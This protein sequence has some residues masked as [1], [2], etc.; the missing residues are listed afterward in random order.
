MIALNSV[1]IKSIREC[2]REDAS[3]ELGSLVHRE[4]VA[5]SASPV[6]RA[7]TTALVVDIST[8]SSGQPTKVLLPIA[9][10]NI[11]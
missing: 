10:L 6:K 1:N 7:E 8:D 2:G 9:Q 3:S 11:I 4:A 5:I